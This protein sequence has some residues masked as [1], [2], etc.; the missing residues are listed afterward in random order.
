LKQSNLKEFEINL[1]SFEF[2]FWFKPSLNHAA[3]RCA[4]C[5]R[6]LMPRHRPTS[7]LSTLSRTPPLT[8]GPAS[9]RSY[10]SV[11]R[12]PSPHVARTAP[13]SPV[14]QPAPT[15]STSCRL[16]QRRPEPSRPRGSTTDP[17]PPPSL[18]PSPSSTRTSPP[19]PP[20][21]F[22]LRWLK[23]DLTPPRG[24]LLFHAPSLS[25]SNSNRSRVTP[26]ASPFAS[27]PSPTIGAPL[28]SIDHPSSLFPQCCM[29]P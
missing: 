22:L 29:T 4:A 5:A 27:H 26:P 8:P 9:P 16:R 7:L 23:R 2:W 20:P 17:V 25:L 6:V 28:S 21:H 19:G 1:V 13:P 3:R 12:A 24:E 11:A 15:M 18:P 14:R 10:P